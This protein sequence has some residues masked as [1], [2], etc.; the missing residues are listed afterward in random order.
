M[1]ARSRGWLAAVLAVGFLVPFAWAQDEAP[2]APEAAATEAADRPAPAAENAP[3]SLEAPL[4]PVYVRPFEPM[5]VT[6]LGLKESHAPIYFRSPLA[7]PSPTDASVDR[8][9]PLAA[10]AALADWLMFTGRAL[11]FPI[12]MIL[13][14][15]WTKFPLA[16]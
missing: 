2:A 11:A 14:P 5:T 9:L 12:E 7:T 3:E 16:D 4:G 6:L 10:G 1:I 8:C 15:P 13:C